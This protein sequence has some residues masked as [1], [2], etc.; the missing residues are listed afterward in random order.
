MLAYVYTAGDGSFVNMTI[1]RQ[2]YARPLTIPP[3][4]THA[5]EFV[6]AAQ[7]AQREHIGLWA[8]CSG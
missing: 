4:A 8:R 6:D 1:I 7:A 2:G 5:G 3:N